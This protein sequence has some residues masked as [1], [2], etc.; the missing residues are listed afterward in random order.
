MSGDIRLD[1]SRLPAACGSGYGHSTV[2][3]PL[4]RTPDHW[5]GPGDTSLDGRNVRTQQGRHQTS[6]G[7]Q[8][9]VGGHVPFPP[10]PLTWGDE[11]GCGQS[12]RA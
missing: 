12:P 8:G 9:E 6:P 2:T 3:W 5:N 7:P 10:S 4:L 11:Y 1:F